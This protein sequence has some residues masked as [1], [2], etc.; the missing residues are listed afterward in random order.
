MQLFKNL[1]TDTRRK[2]KKLLTNP[3][4]VLGFALLAVYRLGSFIPTVGVDPQA[5]AANVVIAAVQGEAAG[6]PLG[7]IVPVQIYGAMTYD[8]TGYP[9]MAGDLAHMI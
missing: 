3:T 4:A 1:D 7:E 2:A 8:L 5:I 6:L 9:A